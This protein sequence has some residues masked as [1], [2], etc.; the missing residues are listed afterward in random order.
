MKSISLTLI[1]VAV[2][3]SGCASIQQSTG[4]DNKTASA[5]GGGLM[6]CVGGA[7][8]AKLGGGNAAVGC[9]VGAAVAVAAHDHAR[10]VADVRGEEPGPDDRPLLAHDRHGAVGVALAGKNFVTDNCADEGNCKVPVPFIGHDKATVSS[11]GNTVED[12]STTGPP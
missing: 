9:A 6:G 8:L 1:A 5:V 12:R 10:L 4:M 11:D 2:G 7:L 3:V